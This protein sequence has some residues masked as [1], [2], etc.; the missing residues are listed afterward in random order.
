M[1]KFGAQPETDRPH[2]GV[3]KLADIRPA[4]VDGAWQEQPDGQQQLAALQPWS[5]MSQFG[6][7]GGLDLTVG[8]AGACDQLEAKGYVVKQ[9]RDCRHGHIVQLRAHNFYISSITL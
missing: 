3:V 2:A 5:G 9:L 4:A 6:H 7:R 8:A 1:G